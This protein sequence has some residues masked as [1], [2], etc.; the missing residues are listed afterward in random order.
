MESVKES[1]YL[2]THESGNSVL[3][4]CFFKCIL[5][6]AELYLLDCWNKGH[7]DSLCALFSSS[8]EMGVIIVTNS[9][10]NENYDY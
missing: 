4:P 9:H 3:P 6:L 7:S 1:L 10:F 5:S 2:G 8:Y